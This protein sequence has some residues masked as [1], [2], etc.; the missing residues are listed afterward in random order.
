[1]KVVETLGALR[2]LARPSSPAVAVGGGGDAEKKTLWFTKSE[3]QAP[4]GSGKSE[5]YMA[6]QDGQLETVA[7]ML[8]DPKTLVNEEDPEGVTPLVSACLKG[9]VEVAKLVAKDLRVDMEAVNPHG[10]SALELAFFH[11]KHD[12]GKAL[13][14]ISEFF[15]SLFH[16]CC[17]CCG[18]DDDDGG[19]GSNW[20]ET[21]LTTL[22]FFFSFFLSGTEK[23]KVTVKDDLEAVIKFDL[24]K[25]PLPRWMAL[26]TRLLVDDETRGQAL[27]AKLHLKMIK[28][29][30]KTVDAQALTVLLWNIVQLTHVFQLKKVL[31]A[32]GM[33]TKLAFAFSLPTPAAAQASA[34]T[35]DYI[36]SAVLSGDLWRRDAA[37]DFLMEAA[38]IVEMRP[39]LVRY[40]VKDIVMPFATDL[41]SDANFVAVL[42]LALLSASDV[43]DTAE[44]GTNPAPPGV[45]KRMI[46]ALNGLANSKETHIPT[47]GGYRAHVRLILIATRSL[48]T[49]ES[50]LRELKNLDFVT[51]LRALFLNRRE[52]I[53][54]SHIENLEE[55]AYIMWA[56]S[57]DPECRE[58]LIESNAIPILKAFNTDHEGVKR[59]IAGALW[60]LEGNHRP[61]SVAVQGSAGGGHIM[62]SYSWGQKVRMRALNDALKGQ[63][64]STWIDIDEMSGSVLEKMAEAVEGSVAIVIGVSS[65]Y[66]DSQACRTEAEYSFKLKK[67]LIFVAAED[68]YVAKGWLGIL[69]NNHLWYS[70]WTGSSKMDEFLKAVD[71]KLKVLPADSQAVPQAVK[72]TA[73]AV[74]AALPENLEP[75][76]ADMM[77]PEK[78]ATWGVQEVCR[79][80]KMKKLDGLLPFFVKEEVTGLALKGLHC[81]HNAGATLGVLKTFGVEKGGLALE[82]HYHLQELLRDL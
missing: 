80:L 71:K 12:L 39:M 65:T 50:N 49:N 51:K 79:W 11:G 28:I 47:V 36:V 40:G 4:V 46:E 54:H 45:I 3:R 5:F 62:I 23:T 35:K 58:K 69:L 63:G 2:K 22:A 53:F 31:V 17:C 55:A 43:S 6:C 48:A 26:A 57:F 19:S 70:P 59:G 52:D 42:I 30:E 27:E 73:P 44:K 25:T 61:S 64:Y 74:E 8:K 56:L 33:Y 9:H 82:L 67:P 15:L 37:L 20:D 81:D 10:Q 75:L 29:I 77:A 38:A 68:G 32:E 76:P 78:V 13:L 16:F 18:D 34:S 66:K 7:R 60:N 14:L 24:V 1:M 72:P 21:G 41:S